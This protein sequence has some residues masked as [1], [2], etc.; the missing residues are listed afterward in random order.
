MKNITVE[1]KWSCCSVLLPIVVF[2]IGISGTPAFGNIT[3]GSSGFNNSQEFSIPL[4]LP[5]PLVASRYHEHSPT[6][7]QR[8]HRQWKELRPGAAF[9]WGTAENQA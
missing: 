7:A 6:G 9:F 3:Y 1:T 4:A 2:W 5:F 8:L